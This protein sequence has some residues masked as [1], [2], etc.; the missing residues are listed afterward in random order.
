MAH[1]QAVVE[2]NWAYICVYVVVHYLNNWDLILFHL[3]SEGII[4]YF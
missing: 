1:K 2:I 4:V 3:I